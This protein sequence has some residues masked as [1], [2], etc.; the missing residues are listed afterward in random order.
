MSSGIHY[1][2]GSQAFVPG[3]VLSIS[4]YSQNAERTRVAKP[5]NTFEHKS[6]IS[7]PTYIFLFPIMLGI[8]TRPD[9]ELPKFRLVLSSLSS[10]TKQLLAKGY[11]D[12][13]G[14]R[15]LNAALK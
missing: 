8:T 11:V 1:R 14:K 2:V 5:P 3:S 4:M 7:V 13:G 6:A 9:R 10:K 12:P 15:S